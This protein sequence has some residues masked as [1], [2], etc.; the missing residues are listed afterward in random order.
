MEEK[1]ITT[2]F[3]KK[4][5]ANHKLPLTTKNRKSK[6][7]SYMSIKDTQKNLLNSLS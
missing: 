2:F 6:S 3:E 4:L 5:F 7:T 1:K